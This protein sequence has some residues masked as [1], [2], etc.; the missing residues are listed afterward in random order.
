VPLRYSSHARTR[1]R[2]RNITEE[3][4]ETALRRPIGPP[5]PGQL[6]S[7]WIWGYDAGGRILKV[8]CPTDDREFIKT[9]ARP[10]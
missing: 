5:R 6:G 1:M 8:C 9:V 10:D 2:Q 3:D 4:V 7:L